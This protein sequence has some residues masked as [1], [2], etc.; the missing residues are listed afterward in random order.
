MKAV[1]TFHFW[2]QSLWM[3]VFMSVYISCKEDSVSWRAYLLFAFSGLLYGW[4]STWLFEK[5]R[6]AMQARLLGEEVDLGGEVISKS[7]MNHFRGFIADG[8]V[9]Y[10]LRDKLVFIPHKLNF[11]RKTVAI[12]FSDIENVSGYKVWRMFSVGVKITLKSGRVERFV[13]DHS[14]SFCSSVLM[15]AQAAK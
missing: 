3:T 4:L 12:P 9:G 6:Q 5:G 7:C 11:S 2:L 8:G 13:V 14:G 10:L 1:F 15:A